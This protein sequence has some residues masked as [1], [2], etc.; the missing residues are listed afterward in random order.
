MKSKGIE[1]KQNI[2]DEFNPAFIFSGV[3]SKLLSAILKKEI[4]IIDLAKK[5][6]ENRGLDKNGKWVG[7]GKKIILKN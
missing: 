3:H 6:M 2:P 5:E 7:F 4:D 1:D